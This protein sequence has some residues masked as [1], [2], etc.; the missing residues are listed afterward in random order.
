MKNH[1]L[2]IDTNLTS[3]LHNIVLINTHIIVRFFTDPYFPNFF[4]DAIQGGAFLWLVV[5]FF[6]VEERKVLY[7]CVDLINLCVYFIV[8]YLLIYDTYRDRELRYCMKF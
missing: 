7:T 2:R 1:H 3:P 5:Q 4:I 8:F 6:I